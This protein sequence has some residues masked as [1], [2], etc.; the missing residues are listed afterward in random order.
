MFG[1]S[2]AAAAAAAAV[3]VEEGAGCEGK[4]GK[5]DAVVEKAAKIEK[6]DYRR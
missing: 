5:E 6:A 2:R 3:E 1:E 4:E